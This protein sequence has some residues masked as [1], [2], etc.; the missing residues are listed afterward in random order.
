MEHVGEWMPCDRASIA[1]A[2]VAGRTPVL[3]AR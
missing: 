1:L 2:D 3:Q